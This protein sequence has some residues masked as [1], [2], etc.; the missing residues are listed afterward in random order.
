MIFLASVTRTF[1]WRVQ[2]RLKEMSF[3]EK[4]SYVWRLYSR[5]IGEWYI[6]L[7]NEILIWIELKP[8]WISFHDFLFS[9]GDI[10]RARKGLI[11]G[12][13]LNLLCIKKDKF[14][15]WHQAITK[16]IRILY[17]DIHVIGLVTTCSWI[18]FPSKMFFS[19]H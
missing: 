11:G 13:F 1:S 17:W 4:N 19:W 12:F 15:N 2:L 8:E 14:C 10:K 6:C 9:T 18:I 5:L 3:N 16:R 7:I